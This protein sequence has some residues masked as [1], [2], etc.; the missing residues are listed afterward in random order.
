MNP[1]IRSRIVRAII[2]YGMKPRIV[3]HI[4]VQKQR[5]VMDALTRLVI[6]PRKTT[7]EK[8]SAGGVPAEWVYADSSQQNKVIIY[9]H[10]GGYNWGS[11]N[12]HRELAARLSLASNAR[13]LL[14][15]YRL[16]PE[17]PFPA[18]L[19]DAISGYKWLLAQGFTANDIV[20]AGDSAG[21]GLTL[22]TAVSL[23]DQTIA[24]PSALLCLS[25]WAD[26]E[27]SSD[28]MN[29]KASVDPMLSEASLAVWAKHYIAADQGN[30][31]LIS[32]IHANF[33]GLPPLLIQAGEDEVLLGD[34]LLVAER[35][36]AAG[37]DVTLDVWP[38]MWHVWQAMALIVPEARQAI[39]Q[40]GTFVSEHW[41]DS[42]ARSINLKPG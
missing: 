21:G 5:S 1:S 25:P 40:L 9:F 39:S 6:L 19:D 31:P 20:M 18:A 23:R 37:V 30:N 11:C 17:H 7:V 8:I 41:R 2:K 10:G 3:A 26:L 33:H 15:D 28:T 4:P 13:V 34:A 42:V 24:L 38:H 32:P 36:K 29:S 12:T 22:A 14:V 35:A 27:M 16:A